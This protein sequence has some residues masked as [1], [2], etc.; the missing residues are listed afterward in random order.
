MWTGDPA[1]GPST[2]AAVPGR[3]PR[4]RVHGGADAVPGPQRGLRPAA[5]PRGCRPTGKPISSPELND[6][7]IAAHL[8]FGSKVPSVQTAV[9]VYPIDGAVQRVG[10]SR[11]GVRQPER[12]VRARDRRHVAGPCGQRGEHRLGARLR[13]GPAARILRPAATSTSWM[14]TT[15]ARITENYGVNYERLAADQSQVRSAEP[16]PRQPEHRTGLRR[17]GRA[18]R[19]P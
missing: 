5:A 16:L 10:A 7:A 15:M 14:A 17:I 11:H 3:R 4:G 19:T 9:H 2:L 12:E 13:G 8:E 6:G 18:P 1:E